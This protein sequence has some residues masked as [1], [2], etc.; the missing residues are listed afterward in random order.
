MKNE[1]TMEKKI[2]LKNV[3]TFNLENR[4]VKRMQFL[5]L[6]EDVYK[7]DWREPMSVWCRTSRISSHM[8]VMYVLT[9]D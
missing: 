3:I 8:R 7:D 6:F 9:G 4:T 5:I 1:R 2:L